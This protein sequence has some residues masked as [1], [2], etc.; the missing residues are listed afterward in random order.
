[1]PRRDG[2]GPPW[3][4]GQLRGCGRRMTVTRELILD[5]V[6]RKK[7][8]LSAEEVFDAVRKQYPTVGLVTVYRTLDL[9]AEMNVLS[10]HEFGDGRARYEM[11]RG[12]K[13]DDHHHHLVCTSC[14]RVIDYRDFIDDEVRLLKK[15][16]AGLSKKFRFMITDHVIEFYGLCEKC[17]K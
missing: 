12:S 5:V 13:S 4:T 11:I 3:F 8:H 17:Q 1:M 15:T 6:S 10:R 2:C 9:L 16:E 14:N 7:G